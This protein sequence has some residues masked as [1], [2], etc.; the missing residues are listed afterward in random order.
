LRIFCNTKRPEKRAISPQPLCGLGLAALHASWLRWRAKHK[1]AGRVFAW[2][3]NMLSSLF[4][5]HLLCTE[6]V[7]VVGYSKTFGVMFFFMYR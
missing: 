3:E 2:Q 5:L 7:F 4:F 1:G 6:N